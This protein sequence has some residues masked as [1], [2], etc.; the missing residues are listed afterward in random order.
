MSRSRT[1]RRFVT[2]AVATLL[3]VA[4]APTAAF[5]AW[6]D[7]V[8][9]HSVP[10]PR[11]TATT[12]SAASVLAAKQAFPG[13]SGVDHVVVASATDAALCDALLASSLCWAYDAPLLLVGSTAVAPEVD[14]ALTEIRSLNPTFTVTVVDNRVTAPASVLSAIKASAGASATVEQPWPYAQRYSLSWE[15]ARRV[16]AEAAATSRTVPS[17]ALVI[18]GQTTAGLL[19]G[20]PAA[21]ISASTGAPIILTKANEVLA[22]TSRGISESGAAERI[23]VGSTTS[24][25]ALVASRLHATA[26]WSS[27]SGAAN[28]AAVANRAVA[29]AGPAETG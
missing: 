24:V 10:A 13:W 11:L 7:G 14:Q 27:A 1:S 20:S 21:M 6:P 12:R 25:S 26:R 15:I 29:E 28:S 19:D 16:R 3:I 17:V 8:M 22:A 23:V 5:A 4:L 2:T 9:H 18:N